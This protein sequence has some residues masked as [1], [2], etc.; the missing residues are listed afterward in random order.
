MPTADGDAEMQQM[1]LRLLDDDTGP[2]FDNPRPGKRRAGA[3]E[4]S[5]S[6]QP[7]SRYDEL[8]D[9]AMGKK[10]AEPV[11]K[12]LT[13]IV[14]EFAKDVSKK[15]KTDKRAATCLADIEELDAGRTPSG[16]RP[17]NP[18]YQCPELEEE[19]NREE[20]T[21]SIK[22][23]AH[24]TRSRTEELIYLGMHH[25]L[26]RVD[27]AVAEAQ[28]QKLLEAT[29]FDVF[30]KQCLTPGAKQFEMVSKLPI[31]VN[32]ALFRPHEEVTKAKA[33]ILYVNLINK[34]AKEIEEQESKDA[35]EKLKREELVKKLCEMKPGDI[36]TKAVKQVLHSE[37]VKGVKGEDFDSIDYAA[38]HLAANDEEKAQ[39]LKDEPTSKRKKTKK[40][41]AAAKAAKAERT[42]NGFSPGGAQGQNS[43]KGG[44]QKPPKAKAKAK[45]NGQ[46]QQ[47]QQ[48]NRQGPKNQFQNAKGNPRLQDPKGKGKGK[49]G[50]KGNGSKG[51][52][53]GTHKGGA[54]THWRPKW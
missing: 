5:A 32:T 31:K 33:T 29:D 51:K 45:S 39:A 26:R 47:Q 7:V 41:L 24:S 35:K 38:V 50:G 15:T 54:Q 48:Q 17:F 1:A 52:G 36:L 30:V 46:Q 22:I 25:A 18:G 44:S 4:A 23:P 27:Q 53:K 20:M 3:A 40:E 2:Q 37:N 12:K 42:K 8:I 10:L 28:Q 19:Y 34:L 13:H 11:M 6:A 49:G 9:E 21:I 14:S 43:S 16:T